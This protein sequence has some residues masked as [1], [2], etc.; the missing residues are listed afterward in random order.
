MKAKTRS[1]KNDLVFFSTHGTRLNN[2]N[3]IRAF[4]RAVSKAGIM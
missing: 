1:I 3:L 4:K 2:C